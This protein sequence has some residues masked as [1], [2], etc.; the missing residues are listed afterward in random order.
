MVVL[1]LIS[2]SPSALF[3]SYPTGSDGTSRNMGGEKIKNAK[4]VFASSGRH[5]TF[6]LPGEN[7]IRSISSCM[8]SLWTYSLAPSKDQDTCYELFSPSTFKGGEDRNVAFTT[9]ATIE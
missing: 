4:Q 2:P 6:S 1:V 9:R 5:Y 7:M 3:P 8:P